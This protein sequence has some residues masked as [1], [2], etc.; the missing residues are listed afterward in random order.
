MS[1]FNFIKLQYI[2]TQKSSKTCFDSN[3]IE[4]RHLYPRG[5][6]WRSVY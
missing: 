5:Y 4:K 2:M 1:Q 6:K 3:H